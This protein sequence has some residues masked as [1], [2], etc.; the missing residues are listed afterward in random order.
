MSLQGA[1]VRFAVASVESSYQGRVSEDGGTIAGAW[2]LGGATYPLNLTRVTGDAV[3]EISKEDALMAKDADPGWEVVS[4]KVRDPNL[5]S[6]SQSTGM[7]G[8]QFTMVNRSVQAM[9]LQ[10]YGLHKKQLVGGPGWIETERWDVAGVPDVPGHPNHKQAQTLTR[11]LLQ[12][13]FGL[14]VH[15]EMREMPV[16][17]LSAAKAGEKM[18]RSTG[19]P[20][21]PPDESDNG[22]GGLETMRLTNVSMGEFAPD[23][24]SYLDR[25]VVDQTGLAGRY[26]FQVRFTVD[27]SRAPADGSAPPGLF[28]AIQ[29]QLGLKVEP[30]KAMV[31]VVV[32]DAV[33]RASA[34]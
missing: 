25:P 13:R 8:R 3:W 5:P 16:Y 7:K 23:L 31:E 34:N 26:D 9:L 6:N 18:A 24:G 22:N 29:E 19:D 33:E 30:G 4:V 1:E 10:A 14:K 32:V 27:E 21:G 20:N 11:K 28:T 12:E 15:M 2:T 17:V